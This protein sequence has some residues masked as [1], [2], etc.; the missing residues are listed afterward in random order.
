[1]NNITNLRNNANELIPQS[2]MPEFEKQ[3]RGFTEHLAVIL[4]HKWLVLLSTLITLLIGTFFAY[5]SEPIYRSDALLQ[6]EQTNGLAG[7]LQNMGNSRADSKTPVLADVH[8][9]HSRMVLGEAVDAVHLDIMAKPIHY[10]LI[11]KA[12]SRIYYAF[13]RGVSSA[14]FG[15][16]RY[17]WG[18]ENIKVTT[19][20]VPRRLLGKTLTLVTGEAGAYQLLGP[21]EELILQGKV[22]ESA[23]QADDGKEIPVKLF[24]SL[25]K[26]RPGTHF[27]LIRVS[28]FKAIESLKQRF[29]VTEKGKQTGILEL[30][31][32]GPNRAVVEST[33]S[34]IVNIY[35]T[36]NVERKSAEAAKT[37]AFLEAQLPSEKEQMEIAVNELNNFRKQKGS[38]D[39]AS[40]TSGVLSVIVRLE[41]QKSEI[42]RKREVLRTRF[43]ASHPN[44]QALDAEIRI[45]NKD[46]A[47][48]NTKVGSLPKTQQTVLRLTERVEV[49]SK[50]YNE[51]LNHAQELRMAKAGTVGNVRI[52]DQAHAPQKP[53]KPNKSSI[54]FMSGL[55]GLGL[56]IGLAFFRQSQSRGV[57]DPDLVEQQLGIPIYATIPHSIPQSKQE[58]NSWMTLGKE[59][60]RNREV[61]AYANPRDLA[62]ESMRS[63]R[64]TLHFAQLKAE[65]NIILISGPSPGTGK[66]FVSVNLAAVLATEGKKVLLVDGDMRKGYLN[67]YFGMPRELGLS[68]YISGRLQLKEVIHK[69]K[70]N[71]IYFIPTGKLPPNPSE[72]LLHERFA[73]AMTRFT[74]LFDHIII[75]SPPILAVTDAAIIGRIAGAA[76][77][78]VKAGGHQMRELDQ[79]VRRMQQAGVNLRGIVFNGVDASSS[80]QSFSK[81]V[82]QY[83]YDEQPPADPGLAAVTPNKQEQ[84]A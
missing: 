41:A 75:D 72:L 20:N 32:T 37:L 26:A 55:M 36:Q 11:G 65:N 44:V 12:I 48:Q 39:L 80:R 35:V 81:F 15:A 40:E 50:R 18:G 62:V 61:L 53:V 46:I 27:K 73:D 52:V 60:L 10:P 29:L 76:M 45:I 38:V 49:T 25:L 66:S 9:L 22:G 71:G 70:H 78:V 19:L 8:I 63:L 67:Q 59:K 3:G 74:E 84:A 1:M 51:L 33:L 57:E 77:M 34:K 82:Y 68:D 83:T 24:I 21:N 47:R 42:I 17:S 5:T 30:S 16:T 14:W 69:T 56:G 4:D 54:M 23:E 2:S 79:S 6:A 64:T 58:K 43:T 13:N 28:R 7:F 31:I